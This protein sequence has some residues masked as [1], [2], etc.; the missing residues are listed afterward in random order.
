L[1]NS[2][3]FKMAEMTGIRIVP[4]HDPG[5]WAANKNWAPKQF[6]AFAYQFPGK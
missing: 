5:Y 6:D 4:S 3:W 2:T 1:L